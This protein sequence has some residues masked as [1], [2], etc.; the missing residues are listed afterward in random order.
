MI[1][2]KLV[3]LA[4]IVFHQFLSKTQLQVLKGQLVLTHLEL[5]FD[6]LAD[7]LHF[8]ATAFCE[9][10]VLENF[11]DCGTGSWVEG[12]GHVEDIDYLLWHL[13][14][15]LLESFL[16]AAFQTSQVVLGIFVR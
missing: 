2:Q 15:H 6:W 10:F 14:E 11:I 12:H 4:G 3:S 9:E 5:H 8:L 7:V 13:G 1:S 16:L